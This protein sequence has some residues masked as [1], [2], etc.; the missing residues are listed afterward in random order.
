MMFLLHFFKSVI[1]RNFGSGISGGNLILTR[2]L[3]LHNVMSLIWQLGIQYS[4]N[5]QMVQSSKIK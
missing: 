1:N 5:D 3:R 4:K 2:R